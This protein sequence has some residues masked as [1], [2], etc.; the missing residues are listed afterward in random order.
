M[1]NRIADRHPT[2]QRSP[3]F[4]PARRNFQKESDFSIGDRDAML[5]RVVFHLIEQFVARRKQFIEILRLLEFY[6]CVEFSFH[7]RD[8]SSEL[9]K[10]QRRRV[11]LIQERSTKSH[12]RT[13]HL[14]PG[15]VSCAFV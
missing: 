15:D 4:D 8:Y 12:E 3:G 7:E 10:R 11:W 5:A 1:N 13:E 2:F 6:D 14:H 9:K